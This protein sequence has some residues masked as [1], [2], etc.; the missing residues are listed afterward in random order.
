[1]EKVFEALI[2]G[3]ANNKIGISENFISKPLAK[4]LQENLKLLYGKEKMNDS[5]VGQGN[6]RMANNTIRN[7]K[8]YWLD[9]IH[10]NTSEN[11]FFDL[12]DSFVLYLNKTCFTSI[13]SYEFHYAIYEKGSFYK[14]HIDQ[15]KSE[16]NRQ[17]TMIFYLN[18]NW[19]QGDGGELCIY[20]NEVGE[21]ITPIMGKNV[22]FKSSE[23]E[24]EVIVCQ[25]QRMSITG[26]LRID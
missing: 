2:D 17:F 23:L 1:M 18:E 19:L 8:I 26:W 9:R 7:D 22:F 21:F 13:K 10:E 3:Y 20:K 4:A 6:N 15:F 25:K 16:S 12:I 14:R 24:H 5:K 11:S